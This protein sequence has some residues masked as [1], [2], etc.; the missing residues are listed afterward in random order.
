[1]LAYKIVAEVTAVMINA[2]KVEQSR[3]EGRRKEN[4]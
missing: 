3:F 4:I 2:E 1:L